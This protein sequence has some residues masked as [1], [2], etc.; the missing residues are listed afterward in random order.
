MSASILARMLVSIRARHCWRANRAERRAQV[1][2]WCFNP[3]PPLLAGESQSPAPKSRPA[4]FQSAPAIAGG[5]IR[6]RPACRLTQNP[7]QSAPAI[8]GGRIQRQQSAALRSDMFQSAPAIAG[9]RI[10]LYRVVQRHM[11]VSIR[12]RHCWRAN[13]GLSW[14]TT[15]TGC[16]NPR[17][18]LLAGESFV[19]LA[20]LYPAVVSI[21]ARHCWRA[22]LDI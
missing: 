1:G 6:A 4:W 11:E 2:T 18:P 19:G 9:G 14:C 3:R 17:P 16:F 20:A 10:N 22:N 12:A 7:F 13:L 15:R 21:R 5:R 8:A